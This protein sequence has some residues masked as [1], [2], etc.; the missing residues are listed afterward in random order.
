MEGKAIEL[1]G[2]KYLE[3]IDPFEIPLDVYKSLTSDEDWFLTTRLFSLYEDWIQSKFEEHSAESLVLCNRKVIF[4]SKNRYEPTDEWVT[5]LEAKM[6]KPCYVVTREPL[7]EERIQWSEIQRGDYYPTLEVYLGNRNWD[8]KRVLS[9]GRRVRCDF[10]TGNPDYTVL[11]ANACRNIS[12][13]FPR[14]RRRG[15]HLGWIYRFYPCR[16]KIGITDGEKGR[17]LSKI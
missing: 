13:E 14:V 4:A 7:I 11:D 16:V 17:C 6:G 2:R 9:E 1:K 10:D 5:E 3:N 8:D 12:R 15:H